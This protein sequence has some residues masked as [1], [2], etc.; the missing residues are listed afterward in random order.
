M[1]LTGEITLI[2]FVSSWY[3]ITSYYL[4]L[5]IIAFIAMFLDKRK[6]INGTWRTPEKTLHTFSLLGGFLGSYLGMQK[7]RH[8][9]KHKIFYVVNIFS[10]IIHISFWI[11][12]LI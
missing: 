9:T 4:I 11:A 3:F 7:F 8:K 2:N 10:L 5:N 6:A 1:T 12:I